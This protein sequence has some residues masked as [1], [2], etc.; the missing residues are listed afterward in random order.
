M[1]T[2][3]GKEI[4]HMWCLHR[5]NPVPCHTFPSIWKWHHTGEP[6]QLARPQQE[7][8]ILRGWLSLPLASSG[9]QRPSVLLQ[10]RCHLKSL[11][12]SWGDVSWW[13]TILISLCRCKERWPSQP[14]GRTLHY[15][16][17]SL[18]KCS[19]VSTCSRCVCQFSM[20]WCFQE[21]IA[22]GLNFKKAKQQSNWDCSWWRILS[23]SALKLTK[24]SLITLPCNRWPCSMN[25][26]RSI[27]TGT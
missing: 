19:G 7:T 20:S 8:H 12:R 13:G 15:T 5:E 1:P 23:R 21:A 16:L 6:L 22:D 14:A 26:V 27:A 9:Y 10:C 18:G 4:S 24:K 17:S 2:F 25:T 3:K 11:H